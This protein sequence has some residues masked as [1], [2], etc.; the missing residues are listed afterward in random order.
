MRVLPVAAALIVSAGM[1]A[2]SV[3]QLPVAQRVGM[4]FN[5]GLGIGVGD[6]IGGGSGNVA[7]GWTLNPHLLLGVGSSDWRMGFDR[8]TLTMGTLDLRAQ[9][10]PEA[11]GGFFLTGG[12]GL[13]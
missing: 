13:G 7:L 10:Y 2:S 6:D 12:L 11:E 9:F 4:W 5:A 8:T 1:P 3:G